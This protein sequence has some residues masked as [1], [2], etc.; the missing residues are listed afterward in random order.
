M[1]EIGEQVVMNDDIPEIDTK[2]FEGSKEDELTDFGHAFCFCCDKSLFGKSEVGPYTY[3]DSIILDI[4]NN[5]F[6]AV[7]FDCW[8]DS[9]I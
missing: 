8:M 3:D 4:G 7:H 6:H 5:E 9:R 1:N 2:L